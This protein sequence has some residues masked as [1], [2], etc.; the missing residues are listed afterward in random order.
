M[1][2]EKK[3]EK[4]SVGFKKK[5]EDFLESGLGMTHAEIIEGFKRGEMDEKECREGRNRN[6]E[7]VGFVG[8]RERRGYLGRIASAL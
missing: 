7:G 1:G 4:K 3:D 8:R 5:R 6:K 2:G